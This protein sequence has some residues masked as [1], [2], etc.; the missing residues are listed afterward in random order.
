[1]RIEIGKLKE[2]FSMVA[3]ISGRSALDARNML[4]IEGILYIGNHGMEFLENNQ[5]F[6]PPEVEEYLSQIK[7]ISSKIKSGNLSKIAG[8]KF[9]NKDVCFS[10]HYRL[11][12]SPE[13]T[14]ETILSS[15]NQEKDCN[16]LKISEGRKL[17]EIKPPLEYD[18]GT[19]LDYIIK[20]NELSKIIYLGDDITDV[21]AFDKL[22]ELK[23]LKKVD[24]ATIL[25]FSAEIPAYVKENADFF[26]KSV[27]E[28]QK[29]FKWLT[30]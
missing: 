24:S 7:R 20:K 16:N 18:K 13:K 10:I 5:I 15:L 21:D 12:K 14:R 22:K 26:V 30:D 4:K 19:V 11:C 23:K 3:V 25:V 29:F 2:K 8:V 17:V 28:V 6:R 1:M 9:E 27:D